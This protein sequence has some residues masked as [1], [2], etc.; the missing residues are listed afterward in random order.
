MTAGKIKKTLTWGAP[1]M[2]GAPRER[3]DH[4]Q[5]K[6]KSRNVKRIIGRPPK[7]EKQAEQRVRRRNKTK[8]GKGVAAGKRLCLARVHKEGTQYRAGFEQS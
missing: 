4:L 7:R 6:R 2:K 5:P 1:Q 3:W 8:A